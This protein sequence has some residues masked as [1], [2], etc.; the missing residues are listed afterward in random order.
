MF[1]I[2]V[3]FI[4]AAFFISSVSAETWKWENYVGTTQWQVE[5]TIDDTACG[6][7]QPTITLYTIS[8]QHNLKTANMGNLG[9][10]EVT[11]TF[12]G[13]TLSIPS[14]TIPDGQGT[15]KLS[16]YDVTFNPDCSGFSAKYY[17]DYSDSQSQ[18]SGSTTLY[19]LRTSGGTRTGSVCPRSPPP[20]GSVVVIPPVEPQ[21]V[22][23]QL[24]TRIVNART[25]LD[26]AAALRK[27]I[28]KIEA[29]VKSSDERCSTQMT[30]KV[31]SSL[32]Q[33]Y[34]YKNEQ[35]E[36][37]ELK[38]VSQYQDILKVDPNNFWANW[39]MAE[40]LKNQKNYDAYFEYFDR[41]ASNKNIFE[42]SH[43]ELKKKAAKDLGFSEFPTTRSSMMRKI[44]DETND[45]QGGS[46]YGVNVPKDA[47][48]DKQTWQIKLYTVFSP[49]SHNVVNDIV[50]LP[51]ETK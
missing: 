34:L 35:L 1:K 7:E 9:H 29:E 21:P 20:P 33:K 39:D 30:G 16:G 40:L 44:T 25:D 46:I 47:S 42:S 5:V 4:F 49:N 6:A 48:A 10:G 17:W 23:P 11:G 27:E 45:W 8:I 26:N 14:R 50:G 2:A 41:A 28:V 18:C 13:N 51:K 36:K 3:L 12:T 37:A 19:G 24:Q 38:V 15:S 32:C 43:N 22:T 31:V